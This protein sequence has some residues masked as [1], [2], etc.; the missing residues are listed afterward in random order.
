MGDTY[1]GSY[2]FKE[3]RLGE[4]PALMVRRGRGR[5]PA[6]VYIHGAFLWKEFNLTFLLRLADRGLMVLSIDAARHGKRKVFVAKEYM[7]LFADA[8]R[9]LPKTMLQIFVETARDIPSV[10]DYLETE[11]EVDHVGLIGYS[12]GGFISILSAALDKRVRAVATFGAGGDWRLLFERSSFPRLMGFPEECSNL[13]E[14]DLNMIEKWDPLNRAEEIP[15]CAV[16]LIN[17]VDD[18]IVPPIC[19]ENLFTALRPLYRSSPKRLRLVKYPCGHE[20]LPEMEA[21]ASRWMRLHL[22]R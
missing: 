3:L 7:T 9:R 20:V 18:T 8:N 10:L 17:G 22:S 1:T 21:E 15:P 13:D 2:T 11:E 14:E 5:K 16:L 12:M 6:V 4:V 19:A